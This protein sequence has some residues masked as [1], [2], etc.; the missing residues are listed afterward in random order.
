MEKQQQII[1]KR[2]KLLEELENKKDVYGKLKREEAEQK[3]RK[4][5]TMTKFLEEKKKMVE[6]TRRAMQEIE[7]NINP[8][9]NSSKH[10]NDDILINK[11]SSLKQSEMEALVNE[12]RQEEE[13]ELKHQQVESKIRLLESAI[14]ELDEY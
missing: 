4:L 5:E 1:V 6:M 14:A 9:E 10:T 12:K 2:E 13:F 7:E 11:I 8:S 3:K